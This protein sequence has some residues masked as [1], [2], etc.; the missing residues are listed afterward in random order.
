MGKYTYLF[1]VKWGL[2]EEWLKLGGRE[3]FDN[4]WT[5]KLRELCK[6]YGVELLKDTVPYGTVEQRLYIFDTDIPLDEFAKLSNAIFAIAEERLIE[7]SKT[8][9]CH[10]S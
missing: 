8:T 9:I 10:E 6:E 3:Y 1:F 4:E 7:Y 2:A 5:P